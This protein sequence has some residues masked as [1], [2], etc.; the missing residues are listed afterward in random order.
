MTWC[1][2]CAKSHLWGTFKTFMSEKP[3]LE[4]ERLLFLFLLELFLLF[5]SICSNLEGVGSW[6]KLDENKK[7]NKDQ[8]WK[9]FIEQTRASYRVGVQR[10]WK[11]PIRGSG[12]YHP[13]S[14]MY[15]SWNWTKYEIKW[16]VEIL[17][18]INSESQFHRS[19]V[20]FL[21]IQMQIQRQFHRQKVENVDTILS[22]RR[23]YLFALFCVGCPV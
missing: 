5:C 8:T 3:S 19:A 15:Q 18:N 6:S 13:E 7:Q 20:F 4:Y 10:S 23:S 2:Q 16:E 9:V 22:F 11:A 1:R 21:Q 12:C 17:R 14:S